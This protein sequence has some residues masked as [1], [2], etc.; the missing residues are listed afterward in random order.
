M[1]PALG[2]R[3]FRGTFPV[4]RHGAPKVSR[5]PRS[6]RRSYQHHGGRID[7]RR[8]GQTWQLGAS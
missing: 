8:R 6:G 2:M 4:E 7:V 3:R 5:P 1:R